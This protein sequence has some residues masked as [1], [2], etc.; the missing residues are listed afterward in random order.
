MNRFSSLSLAAAVLAL[1][2]TALPAHA[3]LL[4]HG[5]LGGFASYKFDYNRQCC[6]FGL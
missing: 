3:Q 4:G 5:G 2:A 1:S 6:R